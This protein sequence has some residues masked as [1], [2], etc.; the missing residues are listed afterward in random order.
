M[1]PTSFINQACDILAETHKGLS[2]PKI[3]Q[4]LNSYAFDY[5]VD[6]PF[7]EYPFPQ[8]VPNKRTALRKNLQAFTPEQ[9]LQILNDLCQFDLLKDNEAVRNLRYQLVSRYG[10]LLT[11]PESNSIDARLIEQAKH[12]LSDFPAALKLCDEALLK[13]ENK[14]FLRNLLDDLR[15]CLEK[16]LHAILQNSKSLENQIQDLGGFVKER[17]GSKEL[18][19][20]FLKLI[21]YYAKYQ[22][23]YIKHD[24]AVIESEIEIIFEITCSLM[25]F[26]V[27]IR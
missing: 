6:I 18:S 2:G 8:S 14:I 4:Y 26:L 22:N 23:S 21:D 24:D 19:N 5:G 10:H 20:M 9:Q 15:L 11:H 13:Y 3:V 25:R 1:V 16:L 27:R 17:G 12:W 7:S